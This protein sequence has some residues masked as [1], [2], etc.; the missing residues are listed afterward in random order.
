MWAENDPAKKIEEKS[1]SKHT[2]KCCWVIWSVDRSSH[3]KHIQSSK[4][5]IYDSLI[6]F[7]TVELRISFGLVTLFPSLICSMLI[8]CWLFAWIC[9][10]LL[11]D[12]RGSNKTITEQVFFSPECGFLNCY[13]SRISCFFLF[14]FNFDFGFGRVFDIKNRCFFSPSSSSFYFFLLSISINWY[15]KRSMLKIMK[16][17]IGILLLSIHSFSYYKIKSKTNKRNK[18]E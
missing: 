4:S 9:V 2:Q 13:L 18:I 3:W 6:L 17:K 15:V 1:K 8:Q 16:I 11:N 7:Y 10:W 14:S 5:C 12:R